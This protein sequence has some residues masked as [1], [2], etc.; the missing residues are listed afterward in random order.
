MYKEDLRQLIKPGDF[1]KYHNREIRLVVQIG[2]NIRFINQSMTLTNYLEN[3]DEDLKSST[4]GSTITEIRRPT[5]RNRKPTEELFI[6]AKLIWK[7]EEKPNIEITV[8]VNGKEVPLSRISEET[9]IKIR[10][11]SK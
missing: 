5:T 8:K 7:R 9:L 2:N 3:Y 11:E 6:L 1:V 10:K 4:F